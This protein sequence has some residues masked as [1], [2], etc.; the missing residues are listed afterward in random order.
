[1]AEIVNLRKLRKAKARS[2]AEEKA[3]QNRVKFGV[4]KPE[5]KAHEAEQAMAD[6]RLDGHRRDQGDESGEQ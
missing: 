1:M 6:R 4:S 3:A 2:E 5:R